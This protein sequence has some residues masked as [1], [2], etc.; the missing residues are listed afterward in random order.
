MDLADVDIIE[1]Q[2][3]KENNVELNNLDEESESTIFKVLNLPQLDE[4]GN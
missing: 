2:S 3:S 4:K 1:E